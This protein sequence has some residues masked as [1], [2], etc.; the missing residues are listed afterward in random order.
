[1]EK[2]TIALTANGKREFVPLD[3]VYF[4]LSF[5]VHY[6]YSKI[7]RFTPILSVRIVLSCFY[8]LISHF[9]NFSTW[10]SRLPWTRCL[11]SL[12]FAFF[13]TKLDLPDAFCKLDEFFSIPPKTLLNLVN[14]QRETFQVKSTKV[15]YFETNKLLRA[16]LCLKLGEII[17]TYLFALRFVENAACDKAYLLD[18]IIHP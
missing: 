7:S 6:N 18:I 12:L 17:F 5:A 16:I 3:Q 9:E 15:S 14:L 4:Y 11:I 2:L 8:L 10:I 1:M 13:F